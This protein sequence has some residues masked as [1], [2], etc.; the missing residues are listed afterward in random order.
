MKRKRGLTAV[1]KQ[2]VWLLRYRS[3]QPHQRAS[4]YA[5]VPQIAQA[6]GLSQNQVGHVC[7]RASLEQ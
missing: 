1:Q 7:R 6:L 2:A 5:S 4:Y 3:L